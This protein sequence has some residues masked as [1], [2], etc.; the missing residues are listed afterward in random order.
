MNMARTLKNPN[1]IVL[2][3]GK[4]KQVSDQ[5]RG[6]TF[7]S[8]CEQMLSRN[9]EKWVLAN[10]PADQGSPFPLQ[11]ALIPETPAFIG[12]GI[13]MYAGR[14][15]KAFDMDQIIYFGMSMFWRG[16]AREWKSPLG[17][18]APPVDLGEYY[19]PIRRFLLGGPFPDDVVILVYVHN[20]KPAGNAATT[21]LSAKNQMTDFSWFYLN[22]LGYALYLGKE[23]PKQVRQL[24]AYRSPDGFVIVDAEF[25]KMVR[26]FLRYQLTSREWSAK[27]EDFLKGPD[28]RKKP[29]LRKETCHGLAIMSGNPAQN[30]LFAC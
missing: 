8:D 28:P 9:G 14:K 6:Y 10:I 12:K 16:A 19:D 7:C 13:N 5:L 3:R 17:G 27:L 18:V 29:Y 15:I 1:P 30:G 4:L 21:V 2:S 26:D 24:C 20:L 25:G 11:D 23:L 22:G